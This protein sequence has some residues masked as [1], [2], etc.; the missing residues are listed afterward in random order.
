M[1]ALVD[2]YIKLTCSGIVAQSQTWSI[3]I[4]A[5]PSWTTGPPTA[6]QLNSISANLDAYWATWWTA[7]K[8]LNGSNTT[9]TG[10]ALYV[11]LAG[12]AAASGVGRTA[13]GS[14]VAGTGSGNPLP[15]QCAAVASLRSDVAGRRGRGRC[16]TPLTGGSLVNNQLS[17]AN[18]SA[19][20]GAYKAL[21]N[22]L[23]AY[24]SPS[25]NVG[26]LHV[27]VLSR[28]DGTG[29]PVS[30]IVVNSRLDI[31]RPRAD[32]VVANYTTIDTVP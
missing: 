4:W 32:K 14:P 24:T 9:R 15:T 5:L 23:N 7:I 19:I 10:S 20:S 18:T 12:Q 3:G 8:A 17:S 26:S 25:N 1:V 6:S 28:A 22:S 16:Y 30:S 11:Y 13:L 31:Q 2:D 21:I 27:N 29:H